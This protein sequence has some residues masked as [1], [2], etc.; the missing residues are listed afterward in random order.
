MPNK[1]FKPEVQDQHDQQVPPPTFN[2]TPQN[3]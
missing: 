3:N 2:F 1:A